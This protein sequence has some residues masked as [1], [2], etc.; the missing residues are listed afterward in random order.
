MSDNMKVPLNGLHS[1]LNGQVTCRRNN[2]P[3]TLFLYQI[4][5]L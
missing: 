1:R 3:S 4:N 5:K 2:G